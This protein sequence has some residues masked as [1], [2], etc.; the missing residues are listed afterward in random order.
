MRE[1]SRLLE[2]LLFSEQHAKA[3]DLDI[4]VPADRIQWDRQK[5]EELKPVYSLDLDTPH[6]RTLRHVLE[7]AELNVMQDRPLMKLYDDLGGA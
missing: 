6:A 7:C 4:D 1:G 2:I 5:V 3:V